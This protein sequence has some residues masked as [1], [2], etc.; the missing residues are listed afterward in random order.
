MLKQRVVTA[1]ILAPLALWAVLKMPNQYLM[2]FMALLLLLGGIEW[3]KLAGATQWFEKILFLMVL[4]LCMVAVAYVTTLQTD[5][6]LWIMAAN[7]LWWLVVLV[8]LGKFTGNDK[9]T[10][11]NLSQLLEG[12][13]VLVPAWLGLVAIHRMPHDGPLLLVFL[14]ILIWSADI[15]AYFVGRRWGR[16][17]LAPRISPGKTREGV[18]GAMLTALVCGLIL[19]W[20]QKEELTA[21]PFAVL[22][23]L[24]TTLISVV[25][26]LFVSML[27]RQ[28]GVKDSG[29][30]LPGHGGLLDRIDS[31]TAATPIFLMGLMLMGVT[32]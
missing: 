22:L 25:G 7:L 32:P 3:A 15:G 28:R 27:K 19:A 8:R 29:H 14:L 16:V 20:W 17:K 12:I 10:G 1:S 31:L 21:Y 2:L 24:S 18:Y 9:L 4:V 5:L 6:I 30:I 23:C 13:I 11:V 26:D